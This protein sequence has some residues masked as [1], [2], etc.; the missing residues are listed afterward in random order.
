MPR[1]QPSITFEMVSSPGNAPGGSWASTAR[2]EHG[3]EVA[4]R[5]LGTEDP[6][7]R[8]SRVGGDV[9]AH[10]V[11]Y[12]MVDGGMDAGVDVRSKA[13]EVMGCCGTAEEDGGIGDGDCERDEDTEHDYSPKTA[14]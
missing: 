9:Q 12:R 3:E 10:V 8:A 11:A 7:F 13:D 1:S 5:G 2:E 14:H 4:R 6:R